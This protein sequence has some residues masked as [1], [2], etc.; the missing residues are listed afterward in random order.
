MTT[1]WPK[2][3]R[4]CGFT[5]R[6]RPYYHE[7]VGLNSR[8]DAIQAAVLRVHLRHLEEC[9]EDRRRIA[10]R[11]KMLFAGELRS[12]SPFPMKHPAITTP[13]ISM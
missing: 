10:D 4:V 3:W 5:A 13:I 11:Y 6:A 2:G 8:L 1:L 9:I 7:E 12:S